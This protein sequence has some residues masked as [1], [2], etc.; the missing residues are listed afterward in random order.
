MH[1][2]YGISFTDHLGGVVLSGRGDTLMEAAAQLRVQLVERGLHDSEKARAMSRIA[3]RERTGAFIS[4]KWTMLAMV[5]TDPEH[6]IL[7]ST[8]PSA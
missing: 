7:L 8:N 1:K 3:K 2:K 6:V 4:G 5:Y